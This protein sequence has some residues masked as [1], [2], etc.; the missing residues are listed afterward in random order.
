MVRE[1]SSWDEE[2]RRWYKPGFE[3]TRDFAKLLNNWII[4]VS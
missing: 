1:K 3:W 4:F 2:K